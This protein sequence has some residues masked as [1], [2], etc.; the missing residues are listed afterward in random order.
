MI[1]CSLS[2]VESSLTLHVRTL[3]LRP[4]ANTR[5][6]NKLTTDKDC[7]SIAT[8]QIRPND[9]DDDE[10]KTMIGVLQL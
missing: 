3:F 6:V 2:N 1:N 9:E 4:G 8:T 7:K 10:E 5:E